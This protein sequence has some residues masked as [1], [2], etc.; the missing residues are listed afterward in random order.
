MIF[1]VYDKTT[2]QVQ[3]AGEAYD[4]ETLETVDHAVL[5]GTAFSDGWLDEQGQHHSVPESPSPFHVFNWT[6]KEWEDPRTL[7]QVKAAKNAAIN[8]SRANANQ[9]FFMFGGKQIAVDQLSRSDI[10]G[11]HGAVLLLGALPPGF[12]GAWKAIDNTFVPIPDLAT[13]A[14]FYGSMVAQGTA[15]F[16]R[17]QA[18]KAQL[19]AAVTIAEVEAIPNW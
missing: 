17:S 11:T 12:P 10:D 18:L 6:S 19:L 15:N 3:Y 13:W 2:G 1:T 9:S 7:E 8:V 16:N 5:V 14:A 4:A